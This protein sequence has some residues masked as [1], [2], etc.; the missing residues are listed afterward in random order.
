[1]RVSR[2]IPCSVATAVVGTSR[3][4]RGASQGVAAAV[5]AAKCVAPRKRA[6]FL[7]SQAAGSDSGDTG[8][9]DATRDGLSRKIRRL[10]S[11]RTPTSPAPLV[12]VGSGT[13]EGASNG[14]SPG[15]SGHF[16][17]KTC[18]LVYASSRTLMSHVLALHGGD[19]G[20]DGELVNDRGRSGGGPYSGDTVQRIRRAN[21]G[22]PCSDHFTP[23]AADSG[24]EDTATAVLCPAVFAHKVSKPTAKSAHSKAGIKAR[25]SSVTNRQA[26]IPQ[27]S[28]VV[29]TRPTNNQLL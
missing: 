27:S 15:A 29:R 6:L 8:T 20:S 5:S 21:S 18:G 9:S 26:S 4:A 19:A 13:T 25:L 16:P 11:A 7:T 23:A 17:C 1:M 3:P 12:L 24:D 10:V 2:D 28:G 14:R 22:S